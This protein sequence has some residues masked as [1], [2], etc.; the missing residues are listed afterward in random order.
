MEKTCMS[1]VEVASMLGIGRNAAY[2]LVNRKGFPALRVGNRWVIPVAALERW[3]EAQAQSR[4]D[5][6]NG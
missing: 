1:V 5:T 6:S 4:E 2:Q 3:L